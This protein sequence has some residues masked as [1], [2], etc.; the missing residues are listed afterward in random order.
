MNLNAHL[1]TIESWSD[2]APALRISIPPGYEVDK[3]SGEDF[4]V[5]YIKSRN[6]NDPSMGIYIGHHPNA[7]A[8]KQK[9]VK[10]KKETATILGQKVEWIL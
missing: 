1:V 7:F 8:S 10:T 6:P 4:D 5:H 3:H 9:R 2:Q